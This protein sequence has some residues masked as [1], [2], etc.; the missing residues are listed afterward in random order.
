MQVPLEIAFHNM[1][2]S[3]WAEDEIRKR[4]AALET[5]YDRITSCRVRV[6]QRNTNSQDT[7]PPVVHIATERN[8]FW[9]R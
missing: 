4:V 7:I 5:L 1:E 8:S 2:S 6:D 9:D 3:A